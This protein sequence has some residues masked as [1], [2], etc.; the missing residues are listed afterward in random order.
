MDIK[1]LI[2]FQVM[3]QLGQP[4]PTNTNN[5]I[6]GFS[7]ILPIILQFFLMACMG[8]F[9]DFVKLVPKYLQKLQKH[10]TKQFE[11]KIETAI[12]RPQLSDNAVTLSKRHPI[13]SL[14]MLRV[15]PENSSSSKSSSNITSNTE[16][17]YMVDAVISY[18]SKLNNVPSFQLLDNA[19]VMVNYRD[20]PIQMT[21]D[22]YVKIDDTNYKNDKLV[23]IKICLMSNTITASEITSFVRNLYDN[24][25]ETMKNSLG[26]NIYFFDQK[27]KEGVSRMPDAPHEKDKGNL[28]YK[29]M[30]IQTAPKQLSFTMT[31]FH[32]NKKFSNIFGKAKISSF[33]SG[34][35]EIISQR[36]LIVLTCTHWLSS[37]LGNLTSQVTS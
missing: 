11:N 32:S 26:T 21:K 17:N 16:S 1:E 36:F 24:Y 25:L 31:Q 23:S 7:S 29:R 10:L 33:N 13:N 30:Q 3:S 28:N 12:D 15:Y 6:D 20:V 22:I 34:N 5:K 37:N 19:Q 9:E 8:L 4:K 14:T 18:I 2:K 35:W 27:D